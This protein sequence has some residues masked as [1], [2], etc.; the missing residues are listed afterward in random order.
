MMGA[1]F[2]HGLGH[3]ANVMAQPRCCVKVGALVTRQGKFARAPML[4]QIKLAFL[5]GDNLR[6]P[7]FI[8]DGH[9]LHGVAAQPDKRRGGVRFDDG[10]QKGQ[11]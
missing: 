10:T 2:E 3:D 5:N 4:L 8:A 6:A 7:D 1:E 9:A 11:P